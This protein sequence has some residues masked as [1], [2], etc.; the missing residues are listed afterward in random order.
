LFPAGYLGV[1]AR[2]KTAE[3]LA[4]TKAR[5]RIRERERQRERRK[6]PTFRA[7]LNQLSRRDRQTG[8]A[9]RR[10]RARYHDDEALRERRKERSRKYTSKP[11]NKKK[12]RLYHRRKRFA[13]YGLTEDAWNMLFAMQ[14]YRC[15]CCGAS[16]PGGG[17]G[18]Q[19]DHDH[20]LACSAVRGILCVI[21]NSV[22]GY[23]GDNAASVSTWGWE[24][25]RDYL[26]DAKLH[27]PLRLALVREMYPL[28]K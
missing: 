17:A 11:E 23:M 22:L 13:K 8:K 20:A 19:T 12:L 25:G 21:C 18:W 1:A 15:A 2:K 14:G 5:A 3:E 28:V 26:I 16:E 24:L 7:Y 6:D 10:E 9:K 27:T 4:Q